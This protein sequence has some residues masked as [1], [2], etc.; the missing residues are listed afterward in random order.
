M[1]RR[2]K[3]SQPLV[4]EPNF[5]GW[6]RAAWHAGEQDELVA[7]VRFAPVDEHGL[8]WRVIALLVAEPSV[9]RYREIPL[10]RIEA[11]VN[12]DALVKLELF[13]HR[14]GSIGA[15]VPSAF[16]MKDS[17]KAGMSPRHRLERPSSRKLDD[18]FYVFVARAYADAVAW[19]L[20][21]RKQL[22][23]DAETPADTVA[24]WIRTARRRGYLSA[25]EPG[26]ASGTM[27]NK[28]T[29]K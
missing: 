4:V 22:A 27:T 25:A 23:L 16:A 18:D 15:D 6:V 19:G 2:K 26:K 20:N 21:P 9:R 3:E 8:A 14:D 29:N 28:E 17:I 5:G 7:Y 1:T 12:A 10:A 11:A 24:R 13:T